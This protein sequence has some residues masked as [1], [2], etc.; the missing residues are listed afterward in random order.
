MSSTVCAQSQQ[1][2]PEPLGAATAMIIVGRDK[3]GEAL[4]FRLDALSRDAQ[5]S[6]LNLVGEMKLR[7]ECGH[8]AGGKTIK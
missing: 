3:S 2:P 7:A 8:K 4:V 1:Q 6:K 5:N